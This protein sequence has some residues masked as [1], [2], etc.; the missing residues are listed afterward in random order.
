[1]NEHPFKT[2]IDL[3]T[4]DQQILALEQQIAQLHRDIA[5]ENAKV[6]LANTALDAAKNKA[7]TARKHV[8]ESELEIK[9]I[10]AQEKAKRRQLDTLSNYKEYQSI[11]NEIDTLKAKQNELE[12]T[13]LEAW[14]VLESA[15]K[16]YET[17]KQAQEHI[18]SSA[19]AVVDEK[20]KT[21]KE[22]EHSVQQLVAQRPEK[23][24][25]VPAE[26]LEK[27]AI[28]RA[29]VSDPV[30]PVHNGSCSACFYQVS[31]QDMMSLKRRKLLSC[32]GCYR[33]LY[34]NEFVQDQADAS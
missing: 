21:I 32:Q 20:L 1:M 15:Q 3:I 4:F 26:W 2:F 24:K 27:Y 11:K 10:D 30:V 9:E 23:E 7:H 34:S 31:E 16:E 29:R 14:N 17:A 28:M 6:A 18:A 8:D 22:L 19:Q 25:Q 13:V 12:N 33:L 5:S